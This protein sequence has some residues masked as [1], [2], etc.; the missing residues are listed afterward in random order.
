M[1]D[2]GV[3]LDHGRSVVLGGV[4]GIVEADHAVRPVEQHHAVF[5]RDTHDFG[6]GLEGEFRCQINN[7]VT[8]TAFDDVVNDKD[9]SML[10]V[11]LK[12]SDHAW[13]ESL[14]DQQPI[15]R[16]LWGI[17]VQHHESARVVAAGATSQLIRGQDGDATGFGGK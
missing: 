14:V 17:H 16:V 3:E 7:K 12:H 8:R 15:A 13:C 2:I 9:G 5:L 1:V 10:E 11:L 6:D 4:L